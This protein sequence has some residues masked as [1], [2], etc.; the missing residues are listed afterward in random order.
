M[1]LSRPFRYAVEDE[2]WKE[3]LGV[4]CLIYM[5]PILNFSIAGYAVQIERAVAAGDPR[6]LPDWS[7]LGTLFRDGAVVTVAFLLY[8]LPMMAIGF[9]GLGLGVVLGITLAAAGSVWIGILTGVALLVLAGLVNWAYGLA[10]GF[11]SPA[12]AVQY[13]RWGTFGAC[14]AFGEM[15][16]LIRRN[17]SEYLTAW[18]AHFLGRIVM[19]AVLPP[20]SA[21]LSFIPIIGG[22]LTMLAFLAGYL[23]LSLILAHLYGQLMAGDHAEVS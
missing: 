4:G 9:G 20:L 17:R 11:L 16:A 13:A 10:L 12:I 14:F 15:F 6:P 23:Y 22:L 1:D 3:K 21:I 5:V 2:R 7:D 19:A 8:G 18:G